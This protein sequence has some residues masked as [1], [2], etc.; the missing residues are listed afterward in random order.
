M[1]HAAKSIGSIRNKTPKQPITNLLG[2]PSLG[3]SNSI[4]VMEALFDLI[5]KLER[6][7][8]ED[9][10]IIEVI[11]NQGA[12]AEKKGVNDEKSK[13]VVAEKEDEKDNKLK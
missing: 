9:V 12:V 13:K 6:K 11:Q 5:L 10:G 4:S 7:H 2:L 3:A 8:L 1:A